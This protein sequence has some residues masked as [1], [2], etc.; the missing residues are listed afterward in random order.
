HLRVERLVVHHV[1]PVQAAGRGGEGGRRVQV[2]GPQLRQVWHHL[3]R[4]LEGEVAVEL[5][6][7]GGERRRRRG[8]QLLPHLFEQGARGR[9]PRVAGTFVGHVARMYAL[10]P[11]RAGPACRGLS[12]GEQSS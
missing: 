4:P 1:V 8:Q 3:G 2:G 9:R 12:G 6:A 5:E 10:R 11:R 7:V